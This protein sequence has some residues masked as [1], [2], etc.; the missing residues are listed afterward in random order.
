M[1]YGFAEGAATRTRLSNDG[2]ID[3]IVDQDALGLSRIYVQAKRYA[4]D[5]SVGRPEIQGFVGALHGNQA[6]HGVFITSGRFSSGARN[7]AESV[8]SRVC[9]DPWSQVGFPHDS[10]RRWHPGQAHAPD[11]RVRR[12]LLRVDTNAELRLRPGHAAVGACRLRAGGVVPRRPTRARRASTAAEPSRSWSRISTTCSACRSRTRTTWRPGSTTLAFKAKTG[13]GDRPEAEPDPQARQPR[14]PRG[15]ADPTADRCCQALRELHHV[16]VWAA[17]RYSTDPQSVPTRA[18]FDPALA[19]K[20][21]PLSRA[22]AGEPRGEVQG[23]GRGARQGAGGEG[24]P[25][26]RARGRDRGA[27]GADQGRPGRQHQGRRPRLLRGRDP[28]P[29]H[30]RPPRGGR[31]AAER[32]P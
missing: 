19:A 8:A 6:N 17:F 31:L 16:V 32:G 5:A 21:A 4:L 20:A 1:G 18:Q 25:A 10:L 15:Q 9:S 26:G 11:G 2:G 24:R 27:A 30:R 22:G 13:V 12:G 3:G 14:R 28:R 29:L 7:Y 23:P